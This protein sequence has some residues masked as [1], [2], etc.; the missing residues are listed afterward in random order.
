MALLI[1]RRIG[2]LEAKSFSDNVMMAGLKEDQDTEANRAMMNKV[3]MA[4]VEVPGLAGLTTDEDRIKLIKES[5]GLIFDMIKYEGHEY[6]VL[7]VKH[8][9]WRR[10]QPTAVIEF[11]L[12]NEKQATMLRADFVK[13]QKDKDP[14]LP[15]KL[16]IVPVVRM[17]TRVRVEIL[18]SIA[19]LIKRRDATVIRS[20]CL[21]YIPKPVIKIVRNSVG[22][23]EL[24]QTMTFIEAVCW[25]KENDL[26]RAVDLSK[27][28]DRAGSSY[29][30]VLTQTFVLLHPTN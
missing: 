14:N 13:R 29:N 4:G 26:I 28:Y 12:E 10:R 1:K 23:A 3:T 16:N 17:A 9:N 27:A 19:N 6:K 7:F 21:Q 2:V 5:V 18:H 22:G 20:L 25:V 11:K 24:V 30:R 8:L 15:S